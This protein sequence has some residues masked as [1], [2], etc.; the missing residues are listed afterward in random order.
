MINGMRVPAVVP[1][2]EATIH[3]NGNL[4][5]QKNK[6]WMAFYRVISS[7]TCNP[8]LLKYFN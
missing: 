4:F 1:V 7:P 5:L 3:K 8:I 2:P 6:I